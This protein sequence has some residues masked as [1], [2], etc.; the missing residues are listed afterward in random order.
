M[1]SEVNVTVTAPASNN[2]PVANATVSCD[3]NVCTFDG[4]AS[5]DENAPTLSYS[6]AF[7]NGRTGSGALPTTT[8]TRPGPS[9]RR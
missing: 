2:P 7:G 9:R 1:Y 5:T 6:W 3:Q 4:R 8:Y